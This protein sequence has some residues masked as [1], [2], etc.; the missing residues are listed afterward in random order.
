MTVAT[1]LRNETQSTSSKTEAKP[2]SLRYR[3]TKVTNRRKH[4]VG[5]WKRNGKLIARI[6]V[7][8]NWSI[9]GLQWVTLK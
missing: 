8:N 7:E 2:K 1:M 9:K 3:Y 6:I 5:I 4:A